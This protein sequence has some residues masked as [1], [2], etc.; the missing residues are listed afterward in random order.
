MIDSRARQHQKITDAV[1]EAMGC[2]SCFYPLSNFVAC[3][4]LKSLEEIP[5]EEAMSLSRDLY[6]AKG[7]LALSEYRAMY[8]AGRITPSDLE[9]SFR[10]QQN[11]PILQR[12]RKRTMRN[13]SEM[14]D[15]RTG[16]LLVSI[17]NRQMIK[18][19]GA[20]LDQTQGQWSQ[21]NDEQSFYRFWRAM[22]QHDLSM[23][24][25]G[26]TNWSQLVIGLPET[27]SA[28]LAQLVDQLKIQPE[29][30]PSYL[31][32]HVLQLPGF[33]SYLKWKELENG[34]SG[35]F[36]DYLAIRLFYETVLSR[37][38][39]KDLYK[40]DDL[41]LIIYLLQSEILNVRSA[42]EED[43]E[44]EDYG[45]AW[46]DAYEKNYRNRLL[47]SLNVNAV[48]DK[49]TDC[50]MVFCIDV[51]SEPIRR[52]LEKLGPYSTYGFA[53]F[54][55][56]PMRLTEL[57]SRRPV[58]LCPVLLR[59]EKEVRERAGALAEEKTMSWQALSVSALQL[60]KRLKC[61]L[62]GAFGLVELLGIWS[63][64]PLV[65]KT[66]F[67]HVWRGA[68][69]QLE[70]AY[71]GTRPTI[72]DSSDFSVKQKIDLAEGTLKGIG[73]TKYGKLVVL[74]GHKSSTENNPYASSLDCGACG[75]N[76][77]IYNARL[78]ADVLNDKAVRVELAKNGFDLPLDTRF[79]AA[80]HNTTKDLFTF[81]DAE[82]LSDIH[83]PIIK[84]LK[85]DL[86][87]AG[88][89]VR[90]K[91]A[92]SLP[93]SSLKLLNDPLRRADDWAQIAPEWGLARNAAFIAGPRS[94]SIDTDLDGRVF[95]HSYQFE[96]DCQGKVLE[97]IMTA[98]MV[99]AQW[100][101]MQYY[102]STVDNNVFGSGS[103][104][105]HN[106][107]G[108]FGIMSGAQ[109]D[110][111]IGLPLQSI[112]SDEL[113]RHEPM[114]LLTLI[115]APMEAIDKVLYKHSNVRQLVS[116]RWLRLVALDPSTKGF[117]EADDAGLWRSLKIHVKE[118]GTMH[119]KTGE[120]QTLC[121]S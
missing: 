70:T 92:A 106:V 22:A 2:V 91:R 108:D 44:I 110:L 113:I 82:D 41:S 99:V 20:F 25:H 93:Q 36:T 112:G 85:Q 79:L 104:I 51:R 73:F 7:F 38:V 60:K 10:S 55:G 26:C 80:E 3:N 58:D 89:T 35:I 115:R 94:L 105:F 28:A 13:I 34:A 40:S 30:T 32:R 53:G 54:F 86:I 96:N 67:P 74:C 69:S 46:Q 83:Q 71:T 48:A 75:G 88:K 56:M 57:G 27:S 21:K 39:T 59:P 76:G 50:Q 5:F 62:A 81:Y 4:A 23:W 117:Y 24:C 63:S 103:K 19:C 61:S 17:I 45:P 31:Q 1:A 64:I 12:T 18:W 97:L 16:S 6:G 120:I 52:E 102:L 49:G 119:T 101:N 72:L 29:A 15:Q 37:I 66:F 47:S 111:K 65:S 98:P 84:R 68:I 11:R 87:H 107:I 43:D 33:A 121:S 100:I 95:L 9:E 42:P 14:L 114:R 109:S 78:A 90:N 118:E 77:G 116:N 8:E